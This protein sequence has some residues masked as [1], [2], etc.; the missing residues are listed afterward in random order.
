MRAR[1][2]VTRWGMAVLGT[3]GVVT[4]LCA[5][6]ETAPSIP[7]LDWDCGQCH[8]TAAKDVPAVPAA[9]VAVSVH[10]RLGC[11][12][13]HQSITSLP[14]DDHLPKV[15][16]GA[17]HAKETAAYTH[18]GP[19]VVGQTEDLPGC[20]DC[21]GTHEILRS[22]DPASNTSPARFPDTCGKCHRNL[23]LA[24]K[25]DIRLK[26][27]VGTYEASVHGM[28]T[29]EGKPGATCIDC[30]STTGTGHQILWLGDPASSITHAN[31]PATCGRCHA[32]IRREYEAGIHGTLLAQGDA[33]APVCTDCHGEHGILSPKDPR[34]NVSPA[35]VAQ[36][37]CEPCHAS[38]RLNNVY[39]VPAGK[40]TSF[41]DSYHGL[42]SMRG[43][44]KV[45]NC[46]SCHGAHKILPSSDPESSIH[47]AHLAQTCGSCHPGITA[48]FAQTRIHLLPGQTGGVWSAR[49]AR[50]YV[51][52]IVLVIGGMLA[53]VALDLRKH[54]QRHLDRR[55]VVRMSRNAALQHTVLMVSFIA[56]VI[57]G[58]A[59]RYSEAWMFRAMFGWDGGFKV[60]GTLHR[61][62]AVFFLLAVVWHLVYLRTREG[63]SFWRGMR[64]GRGDIG[65]VRQ[66]ALFFLDRKRRAPL[67]G[68]FSFVEKAE[69]WALVW[70]TIV[71]AVT[72]LFLWF[73][74]GAQLFFE[75]PVLDVFRVVHFYE[76]WLATL[77]IGVWHFYSTVFKPGVYPGNPAWLTGKMPA[78]M[79]L[80]E[81]G[82]DLN[83]E[84][85]TDELTDTD[86]RSNDKEEIN[87]RLS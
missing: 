79:Y 50:I 47:P 33:H 38:A 14:H 30:H 21:H 48:E 12:D 11:R 4:F 87:G 27:P 31:I 75:K 9:T 2:N 68:R 32:E 74:Q 57:T 16:C 29:G 6:A 10:A 34:S 23:D 45:A 41:V 26:R 85:H 51:I 72:G 55:H 76:A 52:V 13:C 25:H 18:H 3:V 36:A 62:A 7:K 81:H 42:K 58:F 77:A 59:L 44:A 43:D 56:L 60:R 67:L 40:L 86:E 80:H 46:A 65:D 5:L 1:G 17:C 83:P 39:G 19:G 22:S 71:M 78:D 8:D 84:F 69:Y 64:L 37:T 35:L 73:D 61:G 66:M 63:R 15:E 70:G 20:A 49:I 82:G 54:W 28:A 24:K 53:F